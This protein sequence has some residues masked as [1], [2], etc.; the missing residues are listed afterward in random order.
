MPIPPYLLLDNQEQ[1]QIAGL[2]PAYMV[3]SLSLI[4]VPEQNHKIGPQKSTLVPC[5]AFQMA[6]VTRKLLQDHAG[7]VGDNGKTGECPV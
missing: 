4:K 5:T 7:F 6:E 2:C 1:R 3:L